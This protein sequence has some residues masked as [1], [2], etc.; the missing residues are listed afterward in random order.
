MFQSIYKGI[1]WQ[2]LKEFLFIQSYFII[3]LTANINKP[4]FYLA[5][6]KFTSPL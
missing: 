2:S 5:I 1:V 3:K 6:W 4:K